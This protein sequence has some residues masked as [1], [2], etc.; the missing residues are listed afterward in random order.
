MDMDQNE[1]STFDV[2]QIKIRYEG[3]DADRHELDM[4]ELGESLQG[5]ARLY[6]TVANFVETGVC[7]GQPIPD[8][9]LSFSSA[10]A[11]GNP[12]LN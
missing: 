3:G 1:Q 4:L 6:S 9:G 5:F 7:S 10:T 2:E 11:G 12:S 8:S